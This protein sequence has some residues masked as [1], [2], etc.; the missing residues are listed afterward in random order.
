MPAS[1]NLFLKSIE[2]GHSL[3]SACRRV[4]ITMRTVNEWLKR[5]EM[6]LASYEDGKL[7]GMTEHAEFVRAYWIAQA[8]H[9]DS[10][11]EGARMAAMS[12]LKYWDAPLK[13][14]ERLRS[15]E[16]GR[17]ESVKVEQD[18]RVKI[19]VVEVGGAAWMT[20][21]QVIEEASEPLTL[22]PIPE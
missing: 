5:G 16:F 15:E 18:T 10:I 14:A 13:V 12:D 4:G 11:I 2:R 6:E 19:E 20:G 1:R 3:D 21:G 17:R 7:D 9:T 8:D 22:P